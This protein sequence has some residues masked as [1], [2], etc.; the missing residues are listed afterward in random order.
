LPIFTSG[1]LVANIGH[2]PKRWWKRVLELMGLD[3]LDADGDFLPAVT[4][5]SYNA[6]TEVEMEA[7]RSSPRKPPG[8]ARGARAWSKSSGPR[9]VAKRFKKDSG[10]VSPVAK[11]RTSSSPPA[12][13]STGKKGLAGACHRQ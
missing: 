11:A 9:V 13:V 7:N 5:T 2:N 4:L 3:N 12:E 10:P 1:V 6:V 8:A